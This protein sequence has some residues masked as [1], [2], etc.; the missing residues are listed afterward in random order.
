MDPRN[1]KHLYKS[2]YLYTR[3]VTKRTPFILVTSQGEVVE[4][5]GGLD[6]KTILLILDK[7]YSRPKSS[8]NSTVHRITHKNFL[9]GLPLVVFPVPIVINTNISGCL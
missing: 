8:G 4:R 1:R 7:E 3:L 6:T 2:T 5:D 9:L